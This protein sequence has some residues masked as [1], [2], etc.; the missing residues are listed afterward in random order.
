MEYELS[1]LETISEEDMRDLE[2]VE[3]FE[4]GE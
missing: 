1:D 4:G 3:S 2:T